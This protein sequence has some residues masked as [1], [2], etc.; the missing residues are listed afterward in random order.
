MNGMN[1][2]LNLQADQPGNFLGESAHYSGDGFSDMQFTVRAVPQAAFDA[3][4]AATRAAG[5]ALDRAEYARLAQQS[6]NVAP[7]T[8]G[9]ADAGLYSDIVTQRVPPGPGPNQ[10]RAGT[11]VH[12]ISGTEG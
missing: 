3:W 6:R 8:Y 12:P 2:E 10:G 4:V 11:H 7:Y 9:S 5:K 1:T